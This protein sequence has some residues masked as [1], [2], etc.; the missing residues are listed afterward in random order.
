[1]KNLYRINA[2]SMMAWWIACS[3]F[4][5]PLAA[6]TL[7]VML[8]PLGMIFSAFYP[9]PYDAVAY[10]LYDTARLFLLAPIVGAGVGFSMALLQR[11]LL[12]SKLY[13]AADNWRKWSIVGG[14]V[15]ACVLL[16]A[17]YFVIL[18]PS[19]FIYQNFA[20]L[21]MPVFITIVSVF[22]YLSLRHAVKDAWLW[23]LG[24]LVAGMVFSGLLLNNQT[25][26]YDDAELYNLFMIILAPTVLGTITG[27]VMLFLFEKKLLPMQPENGQPEEANHPKSIWDEAI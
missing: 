15:A 18:L 2:F 19:Q 9:S 10:Q 7:S 21:A 11:W 22:Q 23:I 26:A 27:F 8:L 4:I 17:N 1:M 6:V 3:L 14:I 24:N 13:W 20:V 25:S 12:R 5:W 16:A